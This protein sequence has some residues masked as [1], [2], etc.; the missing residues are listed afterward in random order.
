VFGAEAG[1]GHRFGPNVEVGGRAHVTHARV[2]GDLVGPLS[3]QDKDAVDD[4]YRASIFGVEGSVGYGFDMDNVRLVPYVGAGFTGILA[5]LSI[6]EDKYQVDEAG[7][8][9]GANFEA[10]AQARVD[11][12]DMAAELFM[13]PNL[14]DPSARFFASPRLRVGY[15]FGP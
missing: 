11:R 4:S 8:Y 2:T 9:Y 10:G 6:G 7:G 12:W 13:A 5:Y 1:Y 15:E 14:R 3:G